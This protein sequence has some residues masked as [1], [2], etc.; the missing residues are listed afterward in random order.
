MFPV[1][2]VGGQI[3]NSKF[4]VQQTNWNLEFFCL[5]ISI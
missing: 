4:H 1:S 2:P 3:L 5:I